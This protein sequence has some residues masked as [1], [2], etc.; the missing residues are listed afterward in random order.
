[1]VLYSTDLECLF[2]LALDDCFVALLPHGAKFL[3]IRDLVFP[4]PYKVR[5]RNSR[6]LHCKVLAGFCH[7]AKD[8]IHGGHF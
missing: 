8:F 1:M 3:N 7:V 5:L 6:I 2:E 4:M